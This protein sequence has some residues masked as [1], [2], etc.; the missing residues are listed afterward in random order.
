MKIPSSFKTTIFGQHRMQYE[1]GAFDREKC[2]NIYFHFPSTVDRNEKISKYLSSVNLKPFAVNPLDFGEKFNPADPDFD[3]S[4]VVS[5]VAQ[6]SSQ[7]LK[8]NSDAFLSTVSHN[9]DKLLWPGGKR[10]T[11]RQICCNILDLYQFKILFELF[12]FLWQMEQSDC[13][14][15]G[16]FT[17]N[18]DGTNRIIEKK[19]SLLNAYKQP[20]L[21]ISWRHSQQR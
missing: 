8:R 12:N 7:N 20:V 6:L 15:R 21:E 4:A 18:R 9:N 10:T 16:C 3:R 5:L 2:S 17:K 1:G 14:Y 19:Q 13:I 11:E